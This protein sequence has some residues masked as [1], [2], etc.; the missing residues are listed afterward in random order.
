MVTAVTTLGRNGLGDWLIQRFTAIV[1]TIYTFFIVG[2]ILANPELDYAQWRDLFSQMWMRVFTLVA[3]ISVAAHAWIGLW[4][5][6]M[7]YVSDRVM[8]SKGLPLRLLAL[9]LYAFVAIACLAWGVDI[10]W[11]V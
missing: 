6:L 11:G 5:V 9:T 1:L 2:Y 10:L 4:S 8:G 7:D 3:L